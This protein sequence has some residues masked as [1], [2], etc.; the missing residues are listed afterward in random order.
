MDAAKELD[1]VVVGA[2]FGGLYMTHRFVL[3]VNNSYQSIHT[4]TSSQ[5]QGR[6][7]PR[8]VSRES[9][10]PRRRLALELLSR[11]SRRQPVPRV[12]VH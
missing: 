4:L 2:G 11:R 10:E 3:K 1:I 8:R 5:I 9:A 6:R 7:F 12:P